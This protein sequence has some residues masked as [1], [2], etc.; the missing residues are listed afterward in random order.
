MMFWMAIAGALAGWAAA[1]LDT[2]GL[3]A[4]G[5]LGLIV[6]WGVR[7]AIRAEVRAAVAPLQ[8]E[9]AGLRAAHAP[10]SVT[11]ESSPSGTRAAPEHA[12]SPRQAAVPTARVVLT[13]PDVDGVPAPADRI[14]AA[15]PHTAP[16]VPAA[17]PAAFGTISQTVAALRGWIFGGNTIVRAGLAVL[18]VGLSFLASWAVS[19]GLFPVELRLALVAAAGVALLVVGYRTRTERPGFGLTLQGG[20]VAVIYLTLFAAAQLFGT[21]S[22]FAAFVLMLLI[23]ALACVLALQ[24]RSQALAVTAFAGGY[25]V[26]LLLEG[27]VDTIGIVFAYGTI[28]NLAILV[29]AARRAWRGLNLLGAAATFG[30][31]GS[32]GIL[33]YQPVDFDVAQAF[34][35]AN[36]LIYVAMAALYTRA[37]PGRL[38]HAVDT[39]LLFGPAI[40]GFGLEAA[41]VHDRPFATALAALGFGALYIGVALVMMRSR[42][43]SYRVMNEAMLAIGIGFLTLAV[44]LALTARQTSAAWAAEGAGAFWVGMRQ[45]RWTPRLSGLLLQGVAATIFLAGLEPAIAPWPF[46]HAGFVGALL[47]ALPLLLTGWWLRAGALPHSGSPQARGYVQVERVLGA[48]LFLVGFALWWCAWVLEATR[49]APAA[50]AG[51]GAAPVFAPATQVV[52]AM[53]AFVLSAWAAQAARRLRWDVASWPSHASLLALATGFVVE[54]G[55]AHVAAAPG[56]ALW[57]VAVAAH[58]DMLRRNDTDLAERPVSARAVQAAHVGGVWLSMALIADL[59]WSLID[60]AGLWGTAWAGLAFQVAAVGALIAVPRATGPS[61]RGDSLVQRWPIAGHA[62]DYGWIAGGGVALLVFAGAILTTAL[63]GSN[64]TPLPYVPLLN[65]VDLTLAGSLAALALWRR[66]M[67]A[68]RPALPG[69]DALRGRAALAG[70]AGLA[71]LTVNTAWFRAAHHLLGIAWS[72]DALLGSEVVQTGLAILWTL[73]ALAMMIVAQRRAERTPWL[74]GAGL[75]GVTVVKLLLVD[76]D[77]AGGGARI[78]TFI[79]VGVLMLVVGY[80]APLPPRPNRGD[81]ASA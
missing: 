40:A 77:A 14:A 9:I 11:A 3:V 18:F 8:A 67:L 42:R 10:A 4:G 56:W 68:A 54:L 51:I 44:P 22:L 29:I 47:T 78:V 76:L 31:A 49:A 34:L 81:R 45:A 20:G 19:A 35:L 37:T 50:R 65:P 58:L 80:A 60:R 13:R 5:L 21:I 74:M 53:L 39:T 32:W 38:G 70:S 55:F 25:A 24:Q 7:R 71:F 43:E 36:V 66:T 73:I 59:L 17:P 63:A 61:L 41:L 30:M 46:V 79:A 72:P 6:G 27:G 64:L 48:P 52:L 57:I 1:D 15:H 28:L 75:L 62:A 26:P 33:A 69:T 16:P 23:C 2:F 12:P